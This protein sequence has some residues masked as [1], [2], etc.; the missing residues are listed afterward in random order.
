[1]NIEPASEQPAA[2]LQQADLLVPAA[3]LAAPSTHLQMP[4]NIRSL[5]LAII[6]V[7]SGLFVLH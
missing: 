5:S 1:M 6:A 4:V 7:L 2:E 3:T